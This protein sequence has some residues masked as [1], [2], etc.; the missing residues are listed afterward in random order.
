MYFIVMQGIHNVKAKM[1][2]CVVKTE[3][4]GVRLN[5]LSHCRVRRLLSVI[6][7]EHLRTIPDLLTK[8]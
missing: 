6:S 3:W 7:V 1:C 5:D 2:K 8:L 4:Q